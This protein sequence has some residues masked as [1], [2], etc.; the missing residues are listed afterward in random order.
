[1]E[2][3][4]VAQVADLIFRGLL[5]GKLPLGR[6]DSIQHLDGGL[7]TLFLKFQWDYLAP[8]WGDG[9]SSHKM[10]A[11]Q[12]IL[13]YVKEQPLPEGSSGKVFIVALKTTHQG[14]I[15]NAT[16]SVSHD[17]KLQDQNCP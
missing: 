1:M 12:T 3:G 4:C 7:V 13:P 15:K 8:V 6:G 10:L 9:S 17:N 2:I 5:D 14:F 11:P 16:G